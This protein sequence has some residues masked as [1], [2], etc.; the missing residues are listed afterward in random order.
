MKEA[1]EWVYQHASDMDNDRLSESIVR[2]IQEDAI[3]HCRS[4]L[5]FASDGDPLAQLHVVDKFKALERVLK[6]VA[7]ILPLSRICDIAEI[8]NDQKYT[9]CSLSVGKSF[10][11]AEVYGI[12][13][14]DREQSRNFPKSSK[15]DDVV[16]DAAFDEDLDVEAKS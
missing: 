4:E 13:F 9:L 7:D 3:Q 11:E 12:Q 14:C 5:Y 16:L 15:V 8:T 2:A 10:T 6:I 1:N